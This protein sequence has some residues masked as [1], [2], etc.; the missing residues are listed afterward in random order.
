MNEIVV[1]I[2]ASTA[3]G[4]VIFAPLVSMWI[5][6]KQIRVSVLSNN[7]QAWIN[8][9]RELIAEYLSITSFVHIIDWNNMQREDHNKNMK[10][11]IMIVSKVKLMLNP[12]EEDHVRLLKFLDELALGSAKA[13]INEDRNKNLE[14]LQFNHNEVVNLSQIILKREWERVK[15]V[16]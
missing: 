16:H 14:M 8:Q 2:T 9:L 11:L 10:R 6:Q 1:V 5:A 3:L 4:A 7:R 13:K 12:K 15:N